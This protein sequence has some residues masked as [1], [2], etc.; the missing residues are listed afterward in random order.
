MDPSKMQ[1]MFN[2]MTP[3][4]KEH[5]EKMAAQMGGQAGMG[6]PAPKE[7]EGPKISEID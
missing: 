4:Q 7:D 2:S 3:E 5:L 1:E 6:G